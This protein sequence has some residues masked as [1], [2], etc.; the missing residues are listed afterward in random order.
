M[1]KN[2]LQKTDLRLEKER[3]H[4]SILAWPDPEPIYL[5]SSNSPIRP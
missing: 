2:I 4:G 5:G 1:G 3:E